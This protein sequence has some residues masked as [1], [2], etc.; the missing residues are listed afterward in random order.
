MVQSAS[1]GQA[2]IVIFLKPQMLKISFINDSLEYFALFQ[3]LLCI[4]VN[5]IEIKF[6]SKLLTI[7][8]CLILLN[9]IH[10]QP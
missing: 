7:C 8:N 1:K 6:P 9:A 2:K 3:A 5:K 10:T 4:L